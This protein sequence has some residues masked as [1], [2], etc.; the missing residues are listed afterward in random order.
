MTPGFER[1]APADVGEP[2]ASVALGKAPPDGGD[3]KAHEIAPEG[4]PA[5]SAL[6]SALRNGPLEDDGGSQSPCTA[7]PP[8][9]PPPSAHD[10]DTAASP[11]TDPDAPGS[12][13]S[14]DL[15]SGPQSPGDGA[16]AAAVVR[17][18]PRPPHATP[19]S[20]RLRLHTTAHSPHQKPSHQASPPTSPTVPDAA[21]CNCRPPDGGGTASH[22]PEVIANHPNEQDC[23][24]LNGECGDLGT[25]DLNLD[26]DLDTLS[27]LD[28]M[29]SF[30]EG[31]TAGGGGGGG[32]GLA[33]GPWDG[34][35][36]GRVDGFLLPG[37]GRD[38]GGEDGDDE[39]NAAMMDC[40]EVPAGG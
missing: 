21:A 19:R 22:P 16:N 30:A 12:N 13:S 2:P 6:A 33:A 1:A 8:E 14:S 35:A 28:A 26:L 17:S 37:A 36:G 4:A 9:A 3:A 27:F 23:G 25:L 18:P 40:L 24:D 20:L 7:R 11:T 39:G 31:I 29:E 38:G 15:Q 32:G 10:G 34:P 5:T